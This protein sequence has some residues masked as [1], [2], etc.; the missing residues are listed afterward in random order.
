MYP[1]VE[2]E[3]DLRKMVE[4][5]GFHR[6]YQEESLIAI[7]SAMRKDKY[8]YSMIKTHLTAVGVPEWQ[9]EW[10]FNLVA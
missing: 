5:Q 4:L 3:Q 8:D 10:V 2:L 1:K 9:L 7:V 6:S